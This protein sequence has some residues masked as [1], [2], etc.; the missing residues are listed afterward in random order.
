MKIAE[1]VKNS[2]GCSSYASLVRVVSED[3]RQKIL[4][5]ALR[6]V[7]GLLATKSY[8]H[9]LMNVSSFLAQENG[10]CDYELAWQREV[11]TKMDIL[12]FQRLFR[13]MKEKEF[14][15]VSVFKGYC[16]HIDGWRFA[17]GTSK[18]YGT[19]P[20]IVVDK[21]G[22]YYALN[23]YTT[24]AKR[25]V[26]GRGYHT[27]AAFDL[28]AL[29]AK[30]G[31]EQEYPG[32]SIASVYLPHADDTPE[33]MNEVFVVNNT[34]KSNVHILTYK[35]YYKDGVLD[36]EKML[37]II[38]QVLNAKE[39]VSCKDCRF[40]QIC[41]TTEL[42][43]PAEEEKSHT[44]NFLLDYTQEQLSI[45]H[46]I[47]GP[48]RVC[49]GP[50]SGKTA[51]LVGRIKYLH[52]SGIDTSFMLV[53][54]FAKK[55]AQELSERCLSFLPE[56]ELPKIAT[57]HAF[58]FGILKANE[59]KVGKLNL[60]SEEKAV[61]LVRE[62]SSVTEPLKGFKYGSFYGKYGFYNTVLSRM[63]KYFEALD[64]GEEESFFEKY[65]ALGEDFVYFA[66]QY[67]Q[68]I[69]S[70]GLITFDE[71]VSL[72]LTFLKDNPDIL[73]MYRNVYQYIMVDEFQDINEVQAEFLYLLAGERKNIVVVGDD[74]QSI[75]A[76][77]GG[78]SK[79]MRSFPDVFKGA[80]EVVLKHNF[81]STSSIV[82]ASKMLISH[83]KE[84]IEKDVFSGRSGGSG[85][86]PLLLS[87]T[88]TD[89]VC[90]LIKELCHKGTSY[91][92]I[93]VLSATNKTLEN[94]AET[95][96]FPCLLAKSYLIDDNFFKL[97]SSVLELMEDENNNSALIRFMRLHGVDYHTSVEGMSLYYSLLKEKGFSSLDELIAQMKHLADKSDR[98][99]IQ[100][101]TYLEIAQKSES[102][103][104]FIDTLEEATDWRASNSPSVLK[105][106][107]ALH[108]IET[109]AELLV[110]T[111]NLCLLE[112]SIRVEVERGDSVLLITSFDSKGM[113][114][115]TVIIIND[116][117]K[118]CEEDTRRLL[119]VAMTRA[120]EEVYILQDE[121]CEISYL[122]EFTYQAAEVS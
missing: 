35:E 66:K 78:D 65:P 14:Q 6:S 48:M 67:R 43:G 47:D 36:R 25:S 30:Y 19:V 3:N 26:N 23:I 95:A 110:Y 62:I 74:D 71:Q 38:C 49:A 116:F 93:A 108:G 44:G 70:Q 121:A 80:K 42:A 2:S 54:A 107:I 97:V 83:N 89:T 12:L 16:C 17:D 51:T 73:A 50:G 91:G 40:K 39:P 53:V 104:A 34:A 63:D 84:R 101:Y 119:Y 5:Q 111:R 79:Y 27:K 58:C 28:F 102:V 7:V 85:R 112:S 61:E 82:E 75:Y 59:K 37:S 117:F 60:L 118:G 68:M 9:V 92:K 109:L 56:D 86:V 96:D 99:L 77:R 10:S 88:D 18:L 87:S 20:L 105:E 13:W 45:I 1:V 22:I 122:D 52:E 15:V 72:C 21:E 81:R 115:D 55:A 32:I 113:E 100:L 114:F 57:I 24:K 8:E 4:K 29:A 69:L 94:I 106:E 98:A 33:E 11:Q 120:K 90:S 46:H 41:E 31:L 103:N 76:F 64:S